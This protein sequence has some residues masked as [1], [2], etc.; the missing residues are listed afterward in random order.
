MQLQMD[1]ADGKADLTINLSGG[2]YTWEVAQADPTNPDNQYQCYAMV[3]EFT[4]VILGTSFIT[5]F[6][7]TF[8]LD[9][10]QISLTANA[11]ASTGVSIKS[12]SKESDDDS[13]L[14]TGAIVGIVIGAIVVLMLIIGII[15]YCKGK[16]KKDTTQNYSIIEASEE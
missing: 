14:G 1:S 8:D 16:G 12:V 9:T 10:K 4:E 3:K 15:W 5:N 7:T 6:V 11:N 13:G 2:G